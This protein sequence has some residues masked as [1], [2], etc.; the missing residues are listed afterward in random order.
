MTSHHTWK[1]AAYMH[2]SGI[3][4]RQWAILNNVSYFNIRN[5][6]LDGMTPDEACSYSKSRTGKHD[7]KNKYYVDG[8][9]LAE[10]CRRKNLKYSKILYWILRGVPVEEAVGR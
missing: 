6:I 8:I 10:Y 4:I 9:N 3:T 2:S 1:K 7:T 5:H